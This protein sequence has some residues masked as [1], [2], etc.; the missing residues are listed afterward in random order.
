MN[1]HN[2]GGLARGATPD[3]SCATAAMLRSAEWSS[4][5]S[6]MLDEAERRGSTVATG[7]RELEEEGDGP[8]AD[9]TSEA[10]RPHSRAVGFG[11]R[12][13]MA[14]MAMVGGAEPQGLV[15]EEEPQRE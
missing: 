12:E 7:E 14:A 6:P 5:Q 15:R 1:G 4:R 2:C 10:V 9:D 8:T 11:E 13:P 3:W